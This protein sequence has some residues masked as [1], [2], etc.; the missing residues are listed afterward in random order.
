MEYW[1]D[2]LKEME[3]CIRSSVPPSPR[4]SSMRILKAQ[5]HQ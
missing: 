3:A 4:S 5:I 2:G 1:N